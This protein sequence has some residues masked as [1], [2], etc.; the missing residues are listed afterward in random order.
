[1]VGIEETFRHRLGVGEKG[2]F[3]KN[4]G[5]ADRGGRIVGE[6]IDRRERRIVTAHGQ[7]HGSHGEGEKTGAADQHP[8]H[9][10]SVA[11]R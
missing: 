5:L 8:E 2:G 7:Q 9:L 1:M 11:P 10:P 3:G 4:G 6:S